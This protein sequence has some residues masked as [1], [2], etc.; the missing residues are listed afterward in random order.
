[1]T[2]VLKKLLALTLAA[3]MLFGAAPILGVDF[4][5]KASATSRTAD[6]AINWVKSK[7]GQWLDYDGRSSAQCV[8]LIA[9]YYQYLGTTTPGGNASAYTSNAL[10]AGWTRTAGGTP[11]KGDILVYTGGLGH[12]AIY[13]SDNSHYHQN[14]DTNPPTGGPVVRK[15][16][17]YTLPYYSVTYWG[18][19]HPNFSTGAAQSWYSVNTNS[20]FSGIEV[21]KRSDTN[22]QLNGNLPSLTWVQSTGFYFGSS[23]AGMTKITHTLAGATDAPT[24]A[25][26]IYFDLSEYMSALSPGTKYYYKLFYVSDGVERSSAV[27]WFITSGT[28]APTLSGVSVNAMPTKIVYNVGDTFDKTGLTLTASY[29]NNTTKNIASS[30]ISCSPSTLATA[31]TQ[32]ITASYGGKSCTFNVTVNANEH[33]HSYKAAVTTPATCTSAGLRTYTCACGDSYTE[34]IAAP[35]HTPAAD[36]AVAPSCAKAGLTAGSH[37]SVCRTIIV[38]QTAVPATGHSYGEWTIAKQATEYEAGEMQCTCSVCNGKKNE[39]IA[40]LPATV[41]SISQTSLS[42]P[43][44]QSATLTA[45]EPVTWSSSNP[46][47]VTVDEQT[48][49]I[50]AVRK[51]SAIITASSVQGGKTAKC[52]V[53]VTLTFFQR[54]IYFFRSLFGML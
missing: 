43:W 51:G 19:I 21:T 44:E 31:G 6:D 17:L 20:N 41:L 29:S 53:T 28:A 12:V 10:P 22:A 9:Y 47:S 24:N 27:N 25:L 16:N 23:E 37:C 48:G 34:P 33:T 50:T 1:M 46:D 13:E 7:E 54:I 35:G 4:G 26:L 2:N 14:I 32:T 3:I 15:T 36:A 38:A 45:T 42:L 8:D 49:K 18:C 40:K 30:E 52:E 11:Q 5:T 39:A